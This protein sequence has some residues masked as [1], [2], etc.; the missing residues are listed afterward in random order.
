[1]NALALK[2]LTWHWANY[3]DRALPET[4]VLA[5]RFYVLLFA[6]F[7]VYCARSTSR[8]R[9]SW[10]GILRLTVLAVVVLFILAYAETQADYAIG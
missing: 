8:Q 5:S 2:A 9:T 6:G 3:A 10:V 1:M 4:E 7:C